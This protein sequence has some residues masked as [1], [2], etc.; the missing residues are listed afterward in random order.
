MKKI[1][2]V[3]IVVDLHDSTPL[4]RG[5]FSD[6]REIEE[7]QKAI[8]SGAGDPIEKV[9]QLRIQL[10]TEDEEF[11]NYVEELLAYPFLS[12]QIQGHAVNWLKSKIKIE[13]YRSSE[14]EA[15][16]IIAGYAFKIFLAD[17]EKTDFVLAGPT[18]QVKIRVFQVSKKLTQSVA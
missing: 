11:G 14:D 8:E 3:A 17:R 5:A 13:Q 4:L 10:T 6:E 1:G 2:T 18:S 15:T 9:N 7:L 16:N 12:P